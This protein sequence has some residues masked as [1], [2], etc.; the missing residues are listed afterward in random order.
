MDIVLLCARGRRIH[1]PASSA[2]VFVFV[3][4]ESDTRMLLASADE[5]YMRANVRCVCICHAY[6]YI[7][8]DDVEFNSDL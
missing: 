8:P 6:G 2:V 3:C 1:V 7:D 5:E 4:I